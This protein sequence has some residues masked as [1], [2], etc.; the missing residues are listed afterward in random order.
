MILEVTAFNDEPFDDSD[1]K[2]EEEFEDDYF[3]FLDDD[4]LRM[5]LKDFD[6]RMFKQIGCQNMSWPKR[7]WKW[8]SQCKHYDNYQLFNFTVNWKK[9]IETMTIVQKGTDCMER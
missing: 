7:T 1:S 2:I 6:G 4:W 9:V 5:N 3:V 8:L